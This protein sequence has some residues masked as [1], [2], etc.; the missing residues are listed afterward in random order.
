[1]FKDP[2]DSDEDLIGDNPWTPC[3]FCHRDT[4]AKTERVTCP[5]CNR[6]ACPWCRHLFF[7]DK[8]SVPFCTSCLTC[9]CGFCFSGLTDATQMFRH[10]ALQGSIHTA[11]LRH[12]NAL[13]TYAMCALGL[14]YAPCSEPCTTT[15]MQ[16]K[17]QTGS[18]S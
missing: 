3:S 7:I 15:R 17:V 11:Y 5:S 1:M 9:P 16:W 4:F 2:H 12:I 8:R 13:T 10:N 6:E 14:H 18:V